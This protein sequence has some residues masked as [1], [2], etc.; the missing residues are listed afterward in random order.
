MLSGFAWS[1]FNLCATNFIYDAVT[2]EKRTRCIA[3]FNVFTGMALFLGAL[4]GGFLLNVL[5]ALFGYKILSL[6]L[7]AS[8]LRFI[9]VLFLSGKIKEVRKI[10]QITSKELFYSVVGIKPI[11]GVTKESRQLIREEE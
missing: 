1:G 2:P 3:Y 10:E 8:I 9:T 7:I 6:F 4:L 5:P 11:L